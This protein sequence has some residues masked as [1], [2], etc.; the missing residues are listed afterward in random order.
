MTRPGKGNITRIAAKPIPAP[1]ATQTLA[2]E[3]IDVPQLL[4]ELQQLS[5]VNASRVVKLHD[6]IAAGEYKVNARRVAAKLMQ[7]ERSLDD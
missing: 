3:G 6:Q 5:P 7:L 2:A 4:D 1:S